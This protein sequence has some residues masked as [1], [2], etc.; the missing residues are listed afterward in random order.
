M[1]ILDR[2][3]SKLLGRTE[4]RVKF[5]AKSGALNRKDAIKEVAQAMGSSES[6]VTLVKLAGESG[7]MN[8]VG[9]FHVYET[10]AM[11]KELEN[12]YLAVRLLTKEEK[13]AIKAEKKKAEA[14]AAASAAA[15]APAKKK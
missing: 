7:T 2:K 11:E 5:D 4:V 15:A 8:L 6:K 10:E 12:K 3:E 13:E 14:A 9:T 1:Q